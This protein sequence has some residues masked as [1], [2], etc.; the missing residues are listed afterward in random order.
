M[1]KSLIA[2]ALAGVT[3]LSMTNAIADSGVVHFNGEIVDSACEVETMSANQVVELG[4]YNKSE[5]RFAGD[6]TAAKKFSIVLRNCP[7]NVGAARVRFEGEAESADT[8]LLAIDPG[9]GAASG[10]AINIMTADKALLPL[11]GE[12]NYYYGLVS[13]NDNDLIFYAQYKS[14]SNTVYSGPASASANFSVIYN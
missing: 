5:F 4:T 8:N 14:V 6:T 9:P 11:H 12:N 3:A 7:I 10:V 1:K 2:V 13:N